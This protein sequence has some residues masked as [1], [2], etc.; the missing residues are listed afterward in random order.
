MPDYKM[1]VRQIPTRY[2][3]ETIERLRSVDLIRYNSGQT[4]E[5]PSWVL[6]RGQPANKPILHDD[7]DKFR[8]KHFEIYNGILLDV[9]IVVLAHIDMMH[10]P[11]DY[12]FG[13]STSTL[14]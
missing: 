6:D 4:A 9:D 12:L 11:S 1:P 2:A 3:T 8:H 13:S 10:R 14:R 5:L 7:D